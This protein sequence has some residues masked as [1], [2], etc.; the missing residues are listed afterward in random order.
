MTSVKD[1]VKLALA[2][3]AG[4]TVGFGHVASAHA[5][6]TTVTAKS[7]DSLASVAKKAHVS[8]ADLAKENNM[9]A[10]DKVSANQ[11]LNVPEAA[12]TYTVKSGDTVSEIAAEYGYS[13]EDVL[14]A[15][16]LD[17]NNSTILVGQKLKLTAS[18]DGKNAGKSAQKTTVTT[19]TTTKA[20]SSQAPTASYGTAAQKAVALAKQLANEGIPYVWGG[21]TT[22][23]FDCS[24]LTQYVYAHAG[25]TIGRTTTDQERYVDYESVSA[26]QPGDLLFWGSQGGSYHVAI[27]IGNGQYV[28]APEPGQNVQ[29]QSLN[30]YFYPSFAGRVRGAY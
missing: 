9:S 6:T 14:K 16:G 24:G 15:N 30:Q 28:S 23:G 1:N 17:W 13:T 2:F 7:G 3:L 22:S 4:G 29:V 27:Y 5:A 10:N 20:A 12:K 25:V 11:K 19:T 8:V 26:A 21:T 18:D